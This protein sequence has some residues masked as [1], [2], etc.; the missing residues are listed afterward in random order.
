MARLLI[1]ALVAFTP[2]LAGCSLGE[3]PASRAPGALVASAA[4]AEPAAKP[5]AADALPGASAATGTPSP[6]AEKPVVPNGKPSVKAGSK[7]SQ[8]KMSKAKLYDSGDFED[9]EACLVCHADFK[10]ELI[11]SKHLADA[12]MTC[13][14]CH[15]DS[16]MHRSDE[17]NITRPDV[18][19]GRAEIDAFCNQC[20]EPHEKPDKVEEFRKSW[21][22]KR[23][24]TGRFVVKDSACTDCHG[25]HAVA[26]PEGS[27]K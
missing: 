22:G 8:A 4:A 5:A 19:W 6:P 20:H 16:D 2:A 15:G 9:N 14:A 12:A 11:V 23:R 24:P 13:C 18:I 7:V 17:S 1:G 27:F 10:S 25:D 21:A 3:D 26:R